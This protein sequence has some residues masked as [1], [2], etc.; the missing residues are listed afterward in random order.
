MKI[1]FVST[2][3]PPATIGGAEISV[4]TLAH[5]LAE[6]GHEIVVIS[7]T[8][9][10]QPMTEMQ[11]SVKV[12]RIPLANF[13]WPY[14]NQPKSTFRKI[15]WHLRDLSNGTMRREVARILRVEKPDWVSLHNIVG[16][17]AE[18]WSLL[19]EMGF[20]WSQMLHDYYA[21]CPRSTM[22][23]GKRNCEKICLQCRISSSVRKK[24]SNA[25]SMVIGVSDFLLQ[26]HLNHGYFRHAKTSVIHNSRRLD[27]AP[28]SLVVNRV[29]PL[30][31]GFIGRIEAPKGIERLL[32]ELAFVKTREW[33]LNIAGAAPDP[34]YLERLKR[35]Y[36]L[37]EVN[38]LGFV[39]SSSFYANIDVLVVPSLWNDPLPG[40][41]FEAYGFGVPV[42]G[43]RRG[44]IPEMIKD[45]TTG[46]LFDPDLPGELGKCIQRMLSDDGLY[47][48]LAA[49][50]FAERIAYCPDIQAHAFMAM[51][52]RQLAST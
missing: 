2:L 43:S 8:S 48:R 44:G 49:G 40:V 9:K 30:R 50:A 18:L 10:F 15:L 27:G 14:D 20:C 38:Y 47:Q 41:V 33:T 45:G 23:D 42:I 32:R 37:E 19:K 13:Y 1:L 21:I 52:V 24:E 12:Y 31:L 36:P 7:L 51:I 4:S 26:R 22:F 39:Q 17:S 6:M 29:G 3:F 35:M 25:V 46:L 28:E 34:A 16:F 5:R 11:K